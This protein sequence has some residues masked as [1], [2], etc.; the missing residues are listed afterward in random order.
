MQTD[1]RDFSYL[2]RG[3]ARQQHA[4][5]ALQALG[6][7]DILRDYSPILVGTV[8]LDIDIE[9][10]DLDIICEARDL[11]AFA[12]QVT[13]AFG[14]HARFRIE[15]KSADGTPR[16]VADF[17]F[18]GWPVQIFGQPRP[19]T[20]QNAYRHMLVEARVLAMGGEVAREE[21]RRLKQAGV[22]TE[23]A[24]AQYLHLEGDPYAALLQL[25][26]T[27]TASPL[28]GGPLPS[29]AESAASP[30]HPDRPGAH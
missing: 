29:P 7:F 3:N 21:I 8:P 17:E 10:S 22:K 24:F 13:S 19:A 30:G 26:A 1:W 5:R 2:A 23:P 20:E 15:Q 12:R 18:D 6:V 14:A 27:P 16:V 28:S 25:S 9:G 11:A 4:Y